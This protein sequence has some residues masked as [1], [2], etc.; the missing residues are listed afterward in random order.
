MIS[1]RAFTL[2]ELLVVIAIIGLIST[3]AVTAFGSSQM[4]ARNARRKADMIQ[5]TKALDLY[6]DTWG[7]YPSTGGAFRGGVG[8]DYGNYPYVDTLNASPANCRD[9]A[10]QS[11]IPGL[12]SCGYMSVLPR[13]PGTAKRNPNS[14]DSGCWSRTSNGYL[15]VSNGNNYALLAYCTPEGTLS[16]NDLFYESHNPQRT[17]RICSDAA[18]CAGAW[19]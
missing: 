18:M 3:I 5:I 4:S 16:A 7:A 1:H 11:W 15:Y 13:D 9:L 17:W 2:I 6:Y 19:Y 12:T 8:T 10:T 14:K